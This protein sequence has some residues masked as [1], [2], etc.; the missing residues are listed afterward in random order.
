MLGK[1]ESRRRRGWQRMRWLDGIIDSMD[2]SLS[3]L[4]EMVKH[5]EPGVLQSTGSQRVR[6]DRATEQ[7]QKIGTYQCASFIISL[8]EQGTVNFLLSVPPV[9][10]QHI[11]ETW[12]CSCCSPL[13]SLSVLRT[14]HSCSSSIAT[15][16]TCRK[17][18]CSLR[19]QHS[20][21]LILLLLCS[22]VSSSLQSH[23]L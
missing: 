7:Q 1:I 13:G 9:L 20:K 10:G 6:H 11:F 22:D 17:S 21:S 16:G 14:Q 3:K 8:G 12:W 18:S 23:V 4:W 5:K 15:L 2:M 19:S